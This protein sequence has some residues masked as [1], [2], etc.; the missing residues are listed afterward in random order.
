VL[1]V[2]DVATP[3]ALEERRPRTFAIEGSI[4]YVV[5]GGLILGVVGVWTAVT[6]HPS[7]WLVARYIA[8]GVVYLGVGYWLSS[9]GYG[10][11]GVLVALTG[12][13]WFI[14]ELQDTRRGI[15]VGLAILLE[16]AFRATY[17]HAVLAYP[18]GRIR[19]RLGAWV[20][21]AGYLLTLGGGAARA[22]TFQPYIWESCDC[23]RNGFSIWH[24]ESVYNAVN[25]PYRLIGLILAVALIVLLA[26]K[27]RTGA[28]EEGVDRRPIWAALV[29][30]IVIL[31][32]GVIRDQLELSRNGLILWLWVE[33]AGMLLVA[34]SFLVLKR[35]RVEPA[36]F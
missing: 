4:L 18:S 34:L 15:L 19:P 2:R 28:A 35:R 5:I 7:P 26:W 6:H 21:G 9:K 30:S 3:P 22:L 29:G 33:G 17:A 1:N 36:P 23:P 12:A 8:V 27:S 13:L 24:T 31:V 14:P 16:D 20:V 25:D 32:A 10:A 11:L